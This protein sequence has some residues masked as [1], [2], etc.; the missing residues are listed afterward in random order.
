MCAVIIPNPAE[1]EPV[2][3]P[4]LMIAICYTVFRRTLRIQG[5]SSAIRLLDSGVRRRTLLET[6][7]RQREA[8]DRLSLS[9]GRE[10]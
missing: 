4:E 9:G 3:G 7:M 5:G 8:F 2:E 1:P 6:R 10:D